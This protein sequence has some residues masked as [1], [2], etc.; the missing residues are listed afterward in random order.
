[1]TSTICSYAKMKYQ[2]KQNDGCLVLH[3]LFNLHLCE[4]RKAN[5]TRR[6]REKSCNVISSQILMISHTAKDKRSW[7]GCWKR[8]YRKLTKENVKWAQVILHRTPMQWHLGISHPHWLLK[9]VY[10]SHSFK[11]ARPFNKGNAWRKLQYCKKI[12]SMLLS[13]KFK[14]I[15]AI[16]YNL[17]THSK[18][19]YNILGR[20]TF[21]PWNSDE[22]KKNMY[23]FF[24]LFASLL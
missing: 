9:L 2:K 19:I 6:R 17:A 15:F 22:S 12:M 20:W 3:Q 4:I 10:C 23:Q 24:C 14:K 18:N 21:C 11:V 7:L 1:M 16:Y 8:V 5:L 13:V